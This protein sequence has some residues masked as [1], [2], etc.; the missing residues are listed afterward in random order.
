M[1]QYRKKRRTVMDD[2]WETIVCT[3]IRSLSLISYLPH[4]LSRV[5]ICISLYYLSTGC[6]A[7]T[8]RKKRKKD[9]S[10]THKQPSVSCDYC[11]ANS[12]RLVLVGSSTSKNHPFVFVVTLQFIREI[13]W[14]PVRFIYLNVSRVVRHY[15]R[16]CWI[17][18]SSNHNHH[19]NAFDFHIKVVRE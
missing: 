12:F 11:T 9:S 19:F 17:L 4:Y 7:I 10:E 5:Y 6:F 14:F 2:K 15:N 13:F 1:F 8:K 3:L 16:R 18:I